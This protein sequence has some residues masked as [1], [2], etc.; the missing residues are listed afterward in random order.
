MYLSL[1]LAVLLF[2]KFLKRRTHT[3]EKFNLQHN[4]KIEML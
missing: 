2:S 3:H 1:L 4:R